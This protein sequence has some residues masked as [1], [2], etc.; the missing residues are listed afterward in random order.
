MI[1]LRLRSP[2]GYGHWGGSRFKLLLLNSTFVPTFMD[3]S[4]QDHAFQKYH[5]PDLVVVLK[6][7]HR[8]HEKTQRKSQLIGKPN[9]DWNTI[10]YS[11]TDINLMVRYMAIIFLVGIPS[12]IL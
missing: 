5:G 11:V 8:R 7:N 12:A 1:F 10:A 2:A 6:Q 3:L 9:R 4:C